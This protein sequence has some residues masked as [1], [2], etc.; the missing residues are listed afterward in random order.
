MAKHSVSIYKL[1][2]KVYVRG[3]RILIHIPFDM[4]TFLQI[5]NGDKVHL[6]IEVIDP[7]TEQS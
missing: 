2:K 3:E 7:Q 1:G 6:D 4:E 5:Y